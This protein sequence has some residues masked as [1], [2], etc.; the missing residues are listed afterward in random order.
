MS[1][2]VRLGLVGAGRWGRIFVR[3]LGAVPGVELA[4]VASS[5]PETEALLPAGTAL[6]PHWRAMLAAGALDGVI[7]A[8][9]PASHAEITLAALAAGLPVLVE[10]PLAMNAAEAAAVLAAARQAGRIVMVDHVHLF[11]PAWRRL[12]YLAAGMGAVLG[13]KGTAGDTGPRRADVSVLWDWGPHDLA[14]CLD[15]LGRPPDAV[16]AE[17]SGET[18][19]LGLRFGTVPATITLGTLP[20]KTRRFAVTCEGGRLV[21]DALATEKLTLDGRTVPVAPDLPLSV[22]VAEFADAVR[23]GSTDTAGLELGVAVVKILAAC[24]TEH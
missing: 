17:Q 7:V 22:A 23:R 5:N 8:T 2:S 11:S 19:R 15:L 9:P 20:V 4:A 13:I 1:G 21:Y 6:F 3:T 14:L 10:K 18:L 12:K 16:G 24:Q